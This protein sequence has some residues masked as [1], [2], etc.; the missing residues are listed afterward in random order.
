MNTQQFL[1]PKRVKVKDVFGNEKEFIISLMPAT[2]ALD[3]QA[4]APSSFLTKSLEIANVHSL[5]DM[6]FRYVAVD[7][8]EQEIPLSSPIMI[9]NHVMGGVQI[10]GLVA[11]M[12][13]YNFNF[14]GSAG[15]PGFLDSLLQKALNLATPMLTQLLDLLSQADS[16]VTQNSSET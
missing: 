9:D 11:Q 1:H 5:R 6:L 3:F 12:V 16:P 8:G 10:A 7:I 14:F 4:L 2:V 15:S 13:E